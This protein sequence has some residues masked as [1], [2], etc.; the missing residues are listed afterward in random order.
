[1]G[2]V[3]LLLDANV[4]ID[5]ATRDPSVFALMGR[6]V[7]PVHVPRDVLDEVRQLDEDRCTRLGLR[8]VDGSIEQIVEAGGGRGALSFVDRM[9][10][11]LA[12]DNG[13]ICVSNDGALRR[14][15]VAAGVDVR[16]G[17]ALL[18]DVVAGGGMDR[19]AATELAE[20][21]AA[22]NRWIK[23]EVLEEFR[24]KASEF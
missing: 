13:W 19:T 10:L 2:R 18:L 7:G 22:A 11:I 15:C 9:C 5:F 23:A 20:A 1:M 12:R 4:L 8:V 14:A 21:I 3:G 16:W 24:R 6:H 17:L